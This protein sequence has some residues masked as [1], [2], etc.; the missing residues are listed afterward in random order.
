MAT[1]IGSIAGC[2]DGPVQPR[3][4]L[5]GVEVTNQLGAPATFGVVELETLRNSLAPVGPF[6]VLLAP[7]ESYW[8][9]ADSIFGFSE[10][11]TDAVVAWWLADIEGN[12]TPQPR[13]DTLTIVERLQLTI[14]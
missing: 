11:A 7:G 13:Q 10:G 6:G 1:L 14:E 2:G 12:I 3:T 5:L 8:V 9:P 4:D